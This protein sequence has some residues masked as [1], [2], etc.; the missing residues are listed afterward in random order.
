MHI[1]YVVKTPPPIALL[2]SGKC[3]TICHFAD[4]WLMLVTGSTLFFL[5]GN[6]TSFSTEDA[7]AGAIKSRGADPLRETVMQIHRTSM[8]NALEHSGAQHSQHQS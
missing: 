4:L 7:V 5:S 6:M 2:M 1:N 8:N 3:M